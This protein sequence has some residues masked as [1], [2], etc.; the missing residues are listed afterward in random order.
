MF[1]TSLSREAAVVVMPVV[2]A[3]ALVDIERLHRPPL[4]SRRKDIALQSE[5]AERTVLPVQTRHFQ[6]SPRRVEAMAVT[7]LTLREGT[8]VPVEGQDRPGERMGPVEPERAGRERT[9]VVVQRTKGPPMA[10]PAAAVPRR[11]ERMIRR[12]AWV[13]PVV[14]ERLATLP[15]HL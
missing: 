14:L 10:L 6:P 5:A 11:R 3:A 1:A 15:D 2:E 13:Q 8:V 9:A 7:V 4:P 12:R